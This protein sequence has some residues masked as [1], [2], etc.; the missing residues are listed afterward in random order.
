M[1]RKMNKKVALSAIAGLWIVAIICLTSFIPYILDPN[2]LSDN[3]FVSNL[4]LIVAITIFGVINSMIMSKSSNSANKDSLISK[5]RALFFEIVRKIN[6]FY[7]YYQWISTVKQPEDQ[8]KKNE[9]ILKAVAISDCETYLSLSFSD[10][11]K[12]LKSEVPIKIEEHYFDTLLQNQYDA[13]VRIKKGKE[14]IRF[15]DPSYYTTLRSGE[16]RITPAERASEENH[17]HQMNMVVGVTSKVITTII[18]NVI[19]GMFVKDLTSS[20]T[21][22]EAWVLLA[23]RMSALGTSTIVG[24]LLGG[25]DNDIA[26]GYVEDRIAMY[27]EFVSSGFKGKS[28]EE[29]AKEKS[30]KLQLEIKEKFD[31]AQ[32]E[33]IISKG[34]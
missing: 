21:N 33:T 9:R 19:I 11:K 23:Q 17:V 6:D 8:T 5:S 16:T 29:L 22:A 3:N 10:L 2:R 28:R 24:F 27:N 30:D 13:I 32:L 1:F 20:I 14:N 4:I 26:A 31:K 25:K 12:L 7:P 18:F 34:D 15:V